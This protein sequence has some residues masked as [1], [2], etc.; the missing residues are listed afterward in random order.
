VM[1]AEENRVMGAPYDAEKTVKLA[2]RVDDQFSK[3]PA[4]VP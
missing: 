2:P 4:E 1:I 3:R